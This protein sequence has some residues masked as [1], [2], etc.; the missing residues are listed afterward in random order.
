MSAVSEHGEHPCALHVDTGFN[1]LGLSIEDALAL[2]DDVSRPASFS[3]VLV[4]SH[5][6]CADDPSLADEP[7]TA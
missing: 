4:L 7:P 3:P 1:R 2:A 5:L 6:A